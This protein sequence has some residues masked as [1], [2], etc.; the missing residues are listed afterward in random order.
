MEAPV[1]AAR[2]FVGG[3]AEEGAGL[4]DVVGPIAQAAQIERPDMT[5]GHQRAPRGIE[6]D[7]VAI[8]ERHLGVCMEMRR[9]LRQRTGKQH[10]VGVEPA[11]DRPFRPREA[12]GQ[13]VGL[14]GIGTR[15]P[16]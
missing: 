12:F 3:A 13:R 7:G 1:D 6:V 8:D 11:Q 9:R 10:V 4:D 2:F 14:A 15:F 5:A 16:G